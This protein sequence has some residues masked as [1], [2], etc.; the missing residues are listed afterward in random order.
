MVPAS[1]GL[2]ELA[3]NLADNKMFFGNGNGVQEFRPDAN[4]LGGNNSAF[5]RNA[6]SLNAGT[7]ADAR[8]PARLGVVAQTITD[9]NN[10]LDNGWYMASGAANAPEIGAVWFLGNVEAHGAAGYLTQTVHGFTSDGDTDT[11]VYR[12]SQNGGTWTEWYRLRLSETE[13]RAI[14]LNASN[15]NAGTVP[16]ARLP[17]S[18]LA[19]F[20]VSVAHFGAVGDGVTDD[21]AAIQAAI[22]SLPSVGGRVVFPPGGW[23][24][25]EGTI[26]VNKPCTIVGQGVTNATNLVKTS[27]LNTA[28]FN[29]TGEGVTIRDLCMT[30]PGKSAQVSGTYAIVTSNAA[31]RFTLDHVQIS[32]VS[33]G[34]QLCGGLFLLRDVEIR[35][36]TPATGVGC[37]VDQYGLTD[38][39]GEFNN[40]VVQTA[41]GAA[42]PYA[43]IQFIH[44]VGIQVS[45]CDLM[46]CG[47]AMAIEPP[48]GRVV[49]SINV[50]LTYF[51]TSD[52]GG[53]H[54][55]NAG[56]GGVSRL[57]LSNCWFASSI[58]GAGIRVYTGSSV[59]GLMVENSEFYD[60]VYG[61]QVEDSCTTDG[62]IISNS[63]FSGQSDTDITIGQNFKDFEITNCRTGNYGN[64][65]A[66]PTGVFINP[67]CS[68]FKISDNSL[69]NFTDNSGEVHCKQQRGA[70]GERVLRSAEPGLGGGRL[71]DG[72]DAGG[73]PR[74][75]SGLLFL[76][77]PSRG[78]AICVCVVGR[79]S[80]S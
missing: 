42:E 13:Q 63:V 18:V 57:R 37:V 68:D 59:S 71:H 34:V 74:G 80:D 70:Y 62:F 5:Y 19:S 3:V 20:A 17:S 8:L 31:G 29:V 6:G 73:R 43:G 79:Y 44:A 35:D 23:W 65:T 77:R 45:G 76:S 1:L 24:R 72:P 51:D 9:W 53:L 50:G 26:N 36:I 78:A 61:V 7:L 30:G 2:G 32:E 48:T 11:R 58:S 41:G 46:Q 16:L 40:L 75:H 33:R 55:N 66:S 39:V 56:G 25:V 22:D 15:L 69:H 12:R 21:T 54:I 10:A 64:F 60:S 47:K 14:Y 67:G 4:T 28:F 27:S 49:T 38:G 52:V